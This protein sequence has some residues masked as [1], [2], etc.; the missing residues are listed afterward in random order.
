M[1]YMRKCFTVAFVLVLVCALFSGCSEQAMMDRIM[2]GEYYG[3]CPCNTYILNS[4]IPIENEIKAKYEAYLPQEKAFSVSGYD[5]TTVRYQYSKFD[6]K[7]MRYI[8]IYTFNAKA[9][10]GSWNNCGYDFP[11]YNGQVS[12]GAVYHNDKLAKFG[13]RV[14]DEGRALSEMGNAVLNDLCSVDGLKASVEESEVK[15][16][17]KYVDDSILPAVTYSITVEDKGEYVDISYNRS[18][19]WDKAPTEEVKASIDI[20]KYYKL[21]EKKL[22]ISAQKAGDEPIDVVAEYEPE[23]YI[24]EAGEISIFYRRMIVNM[25]QDSLHRGISSVCVHTGR[26][27]NK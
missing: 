21:V 20:D 9:D 3:W 7:M 4:S 23:I 12:A 16:Y 19:S 15:Y 1:R 5:F 13:L 18:K 27:I 14:A 2:L 24:T 10:L 17:A 8:N 26:Y 6:R 22:I 25:A 11:E